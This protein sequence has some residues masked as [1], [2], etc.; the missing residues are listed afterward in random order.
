MTSRLQAVLRADFSSL[1]DATGNE[2]VLGAMGD[3]TLV[4]C[5]RKSTE[6]SVIRHAIGIFSK[7][8]FDRPTDYHVQIRKGN[9]S[10]EIVV[11]DETM[12][13]HYV[14]SAPEGILLASA[15]CK[16]E[17]PEKNGAICDFSGRLV[18]RLTLGDGIADLR[19]ISDGT[20]WAS[21]FDE[22]V[23]GNYGWGS[24]EPAPIGASGLVAFDSGG[25]PKFSYDAQAAGTDSICD[26]YAMNVS[27]TGD[28]WVYFYTE[29]SIVRIGREGYRVWTLGMG[30]A[31]ALAV[32]GD[33][34]L[35]YGDYKKSGIA[36]RIAL[37]GDGTAAVE[38]SL[39]IVGADG[40][41]IVARGYGIGEK[42]YLFDRG[43]IYTV[44]D[45]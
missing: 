35:L 8:R 25:A 28:V 7:S 36:R 17:G 11:R 38:E 40:N 43:R 10:R 14:Q 6:S 41:P 42:L 20:I 3:G 31:R 27:E 2:P 24:P 4:A 26:A 30:G 44:E 9:E 23:F 21:Y 39:E 1:S 12:A 15:R 22:G 45:W 34:I 33:R 16:A 5:A 29:F 13:V 19:V 37:L 18:R 32:R